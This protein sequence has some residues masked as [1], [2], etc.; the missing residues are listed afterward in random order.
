MWGERGT[1]GL[2]QQAQQREHD[3]FHGGGVEVGRVDHV[4]QTVLGNHA[5]HGRGKDATVGLKDMN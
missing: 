3:Q 5:T 4:Q 2:A 1:E